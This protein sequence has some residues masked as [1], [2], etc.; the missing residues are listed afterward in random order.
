MV[1]LFVPIPTIRAPIFMRAIPSCCTCGSLAA[2]RITVRPFAS[3]APNRAFSVAVTDG[4]SSR[5]SAPTRPSVCIPYPPG[6]RSSSAPSA[7]SAWKWGSLR[8]RPMT[9]PPG[10]P[11]RTLLCRP[12]SEPANNSEVRIS[13]A[14]D[15]GTSVVRT[16]DPVIRT[17]W[18][19]SSST[20]APSPLA[21]SSIPRT[22][23]MRGTLRSVMGSSI[24]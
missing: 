1:M 7:R 18:G 13:F 14:R 4:S 17:V 5:M 12:R 6:A 23:R 8:R 10:R 22:S 9:S 2:L 16:P 20:V 3:A 21:I 19:S 15:A 11:R 24:S